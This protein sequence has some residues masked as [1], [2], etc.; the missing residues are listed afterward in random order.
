MI[1]GVIFD[2]DGIIV[3]SEPLHMEAL[4]E[5]IKK[6]VCD[7]I[8]V[9]EDELIGLTLDETIRKF[10]IEDSKNQGIKDA[11]LKYYIEKLSEKLIRKD[12]KKLW[13][14]LIK[15]NIKFGCVSTAE[16][17]IC[18][19]NVNLLGIGDKKKVPIVALESVEKSKPHPLPYL[20]MLNMLNL[21]ADEV[22]VLE[23]SDI[24]I[25]AAV[26]A[27]IRDVYAWPHNLSTSQ[28]YNQ[29]K[30]VISD[31][32]DVEFFNNIMN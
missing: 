31:L 6:E 20:T 16:M 22:I 3:D 4:I 12:M 17:K 1:K 21:K 28:K 23:D 29:A 5:S 14:S 11:T 19:A 15:K 24:G 25:S 7:S 8:E 27:G 18:Q 13:M 26:S 2:I 32:R 30:K 9:K 10:G